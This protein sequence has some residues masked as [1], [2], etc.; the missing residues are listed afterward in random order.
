MTTVNSSKKRIYK[1]DLISLGKRIRKARTASNLTC[2][3]LAKLIGVSTASVVNYEKG[4]RGVNISKLKLIA[5]YTNTPIYKLMGES[6][7]SIMDS[8]E[9]SALY[10]SKESAS[11]KLKMLSSSGFLNDDLSNDLYDIS[12]CLISENWG[13]EKAS[14]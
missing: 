8:D 10:M 4:T 12:Q 6:D 9:G 3:E 1:R 7:K 14:Y 13:M 2:E 11:D 5:K